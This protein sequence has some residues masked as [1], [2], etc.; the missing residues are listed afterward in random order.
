[1]RALEYSPQ[2]EP[3]QTVVASRY[4]MALSAKNA[5]LKPMEAPVAVGTV[6]WSCQRGSSPRAEWQMSVSCEPRRGATPRMM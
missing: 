1:V 6:S 2:L 5:A 4:W 3:L